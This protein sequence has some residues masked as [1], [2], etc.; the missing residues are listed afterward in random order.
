[1]MGLS[2]PAIIG[3]FFLTL[4]STLLRLCLELIAFKKC[5]NPWWQVKGLF[6][7]NWSFNIFISFFK[8][9]HCIIDFI[10][11]IRFKMRS[12]ASLYSSY[13]LQ[14]SWSFWFGTIG[15]TLHQN[16]RFGQQ[17]GKIVRFPPLSYLLDTR[18]SHIF[19]CWQ[20]N[21]CSLL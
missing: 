10:G 3:C 20:I 21:W 8:G 7:N 16:C 11:K 17:S 1:M 6:F 15:L 2:F 9:F 14:M 18:N 12:F 19:L 5:N 4:C 13:L